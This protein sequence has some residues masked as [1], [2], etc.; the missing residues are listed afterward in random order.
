MGSWPSLLY[1]QSV[2]SAEINLCFILWVSR[3]LTETIKTLKT[4]G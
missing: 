2:L 1:M 4:L 3:T